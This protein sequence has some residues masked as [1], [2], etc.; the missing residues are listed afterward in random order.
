MKVYL[1]G[2]LR[3]KRIPELA[4]KLRGTG[5]D[6][7]DDWYAAGEDADDYWRDYERARG[8]DFVQ[9]LDGHAAEH[10][11]EFDRDH[12][13]SCDVAVLVGPAGKSAH[14]EA[15]YVIGRRTRCYALIDQD[16]ERY[17]VMYKFFD[18]VFN[19]ERDLISV[20]TDDQDQFD[21]AGF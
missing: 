11:F 15:G 5:I 17:D 3:N 2:S 7:F 13:E 16:P 8:H 4:E 21:N 14:L 6:V 10:V 18:G 9:A 12:L 19:T 20:L 1:I